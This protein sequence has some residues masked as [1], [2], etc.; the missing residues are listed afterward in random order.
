MDADYT[1]ADGEIDFVGTADDHRR[2]RPLPGHRRQ[3]ARR[4]RPQHDRRTERRGHAW[5]AVSATEPESGGRPPN[6]LLL[7]TDQQRQPRHW[8]D[9]PGWLQQLMPNDAEL[10]RTG[11]SFN[12]GFCNTAM[13]S[14]SRATPAHR[15]VP[16]RARGRADADR[17][18]P[19]ARPAQL[20]GGRRPRWPA[21][22]RR[23][24]AP[25]RRVLCAVRAR[26]PRPRPQH[27][28]RARAAARHPDAGDA[29]ARA[30]LP[31]RLQG[32]VAPHPSARAE[33]SSDA[34]RLERAR[35][36]AARARLRL[37]RLGAARRRR[38][39]QGEPTSAAAT[40]AS[41]EGWD[42]VYTRQVER[43]LGEPDLPEPF[44]LV[45]SLVNPH[46]VLGYP[47]RTWAAAT[48]PR[49]SATSASSCRRPSTRTSR[50][51]PPC[52]R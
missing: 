19:A 44:C 22:P 45:V 26:R 17:G 49:S 30:R 27:R 32:Q 20:P 14:P 41:G 18:R 25:K 16:G 5:T 37:R 29:A 28:R 50:A 1:V 9:D 36:R 38:E 12:N 15:H 11:L 34:R 6:M 52:T 8:P 3:A 43:W 39:R 35:R 42:E 2:H 47:A 31:R 7:I 48:R 40:P 46:D 4:A 23:G 21:D 51:S 33:A 13:C 24:E 10:A